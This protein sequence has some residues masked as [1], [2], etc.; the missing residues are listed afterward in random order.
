MKIASES[1]LGGNFVEITPGGSETMLA[2]GD[3][4]VN[5]PGLGQPAQPADAVRDR[6]VIRGLLLGAGAGRWRR[7]QA[8]AAQSAQAVNGEAV[9]EVRDLHLRGLD[10][11]NGSAQ[12]ID[13]R[14][15]ETVRFGYLEI[16]AERCRVPR[17]D[18]AATPT[19]SWHPRHPR[20]DAALLGLDVRV[21]AGAVGAGPSA[22]RRLGW[23]RAG[24][25]GT[26]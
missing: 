6:Q 1:L 22:L 20:A 10:S 9:V 2:A 21:V 26:D 18:P 16:T 3:E 7:R 23:L 24:E 13:L 14:V 4:I 17:D 11:L 25:A 15:G 8:V 19:P 12:D 5:T